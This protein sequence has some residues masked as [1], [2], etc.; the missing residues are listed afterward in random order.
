MLLCG[1]SD[2]LRNSTPRSTLLSYFFCQ[3]TDSR[4]NSAAAVLRGLLY[5]RLHQQSSLVSHVRRK[6]N[7]AGKSLFEDTNA[8]AALSEIFADVL[9]D[10]SL[11][12]TYLI[13]DMLEE[14][15][16]DRPKLLSFIAKQSS[17]S[18]RIK[19]VVSSR[20]W[21]VIREQLETAEHKTRLS[22]ELNAESVAAAVKIFIQ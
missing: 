2:E 14:C 13:I 8:W 16:A 5:I 3:T 17:A 1:I 18:P 10:T 4:I 12:T 19:W 21:P 9:R 22:L 20:N 11:S 7:H 15:V 6:Y